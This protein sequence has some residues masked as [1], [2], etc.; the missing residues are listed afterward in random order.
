V[1]SYVRE[2]ASYWIVY[3]SHARNTP[4]VKAFRDWISAEFAA[5]I[6]ADPTGHYLPR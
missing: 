6:A 1:P 5:E 2:L 4:K 3:P